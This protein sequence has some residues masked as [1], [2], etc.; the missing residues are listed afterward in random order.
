MEVILTPIAIKRAIQFAEDS[1]I[2]EV[3]CYEDLSGRHFVTN[4]APSVC[5][6]EDMHPQYHTQDG[7]YIKL[8]TLRTLLI[9]NRTVSILQEGDSVI[10]KY[11]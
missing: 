10:I 8:R 2:N 9:N 7:T 11:L 6:D 4:P 5:L 1:G 3:F